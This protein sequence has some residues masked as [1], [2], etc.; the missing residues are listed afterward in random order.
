M[1]RRPHLLKLVVTQPQGFLLH[2]ALGHAHG[3][4]V[5]SLGSLGVLCD[6]SYDVDFGRAR[7]VF[8]GR[9]EIGILV[10]VEGRGKLRPAV[11]RLLEVYLIRL[12]FAYFLC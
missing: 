5:P 9:L 1:G 12:C 2:L 4:G 3:M 11:L 6:V 10:F 8:F 7:L